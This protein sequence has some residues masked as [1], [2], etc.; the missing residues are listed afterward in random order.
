MNIWSSMVNESYLSLTAY[1][2]TSNNRV[3]SLTMDNETT[4]VACCSLL[5]NELDNEFNSLGFSHYCCSAYVINLA[6]QQGLK[7]IGS[8]L[9]KL[10]K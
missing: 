9:K 10:R 6:V 5:A 3:I 4:M 7:A 1:Y 2:I 8:E